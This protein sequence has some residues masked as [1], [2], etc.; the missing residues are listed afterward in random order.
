MVE[1]DNLRYKG[2][3][4]FK[5]SGLRFMLGRVKSVL[6]NIQLHTGDTKHLPFF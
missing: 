2:S 3:H 6:R 1:K 5:I 4:S